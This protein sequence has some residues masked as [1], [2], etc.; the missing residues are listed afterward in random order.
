MVGRLLEP[1]EQ[2]TGPLGLY[3]IGRE[4]VEDVKE[5]KLYILR[6]FQWRKTELCNLGT[7]TN[8]GALLDNPLGALRIALVKVAESFAAESGG[9]ANDIVRLEV[10]TKTNGH[11]AS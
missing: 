5:R 8:V 4:R 3:A 9:A 1:E 2:G 10:G 11:K 6:G 7:T